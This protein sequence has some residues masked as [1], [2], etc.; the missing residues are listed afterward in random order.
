MTA[1]SGNIYGVVLNDSDERAELEASLHEAPYG[2]PPVAPVVFMKPRTCLSGWSAPADAVV[3][4]LAQQLVCSLPC[5]L[6]KMLR[7][8]RRIRWRAALALPR[9]RLICLC[10]SPITI[11][12][13]SLFETPMAH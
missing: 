13:R 9:W 11:G 4:A 3:Q 2:K 6:R 8:W 10:R 12:L 7:Q 1:F 5:C